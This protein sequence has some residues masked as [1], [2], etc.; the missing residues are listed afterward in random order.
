MGKKG[1]TIPQNRRKINKWKGKNQFW[2]V[3]RRIVRTLALVVR[4]LDPVAGE[5]LDEDTL[6]HPGL[7]ALLLATGGR[8]RAPRAGG[9]A[10]SPTTVSAAAVVDAAF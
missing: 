3:R 10:W 2:C 9:K 1:K 7:D 5:P 4:K 6:D 8:T